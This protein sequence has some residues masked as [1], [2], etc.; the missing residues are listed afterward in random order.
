MSDR[1]NQDCIIARRPCCG[2]IVFA[3]A[4][5]KEVMDDEMRREI[6]VM[7]EEGYVIEHMSAKDVRAADWGCKCGT[8]TAA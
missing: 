4:N 2:R 3:A 5:V 8:K 7:V 1:D 6:G